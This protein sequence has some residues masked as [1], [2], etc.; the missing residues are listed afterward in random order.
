MGKKTGFAIERRTFFSCDSL[1][2]GGSECCRFGRVALYHGC[3]AWRRHPECDGAAREFT[4]AADA[5]RKLSQIPAPLLKWV[6][7]C[8]ATHSTDGHRVSQQSSHAFRLP[9]DCAS[10]YGRIATEQLARLLR[11]F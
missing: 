4:S 8:F 10:G 1:G 5:R 2:R 9:N 6:V 11:S 3:W 7:E